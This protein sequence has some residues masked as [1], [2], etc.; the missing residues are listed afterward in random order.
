MIVEDSPAKYVLNTVENVILPK[1]GTC[2]G[3]G[4]SNTYFIDTLLP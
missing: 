1:S 3:A 4:Q 2:V